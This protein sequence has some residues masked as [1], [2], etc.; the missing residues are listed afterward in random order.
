MRHVVCIALLMVAASVAAP[1][2][3][4]PLILTLAEAQIETTPDPRAR[5]PDPN[6]PAPANDLPPLQEPGV[7]TPIGTEDSTTTTTT[8]TTAEPAKGSDNQLSSVQWLGIAVAAIAVGALAVA[9]GGGGGDEPQ[10][11]GSSG[12]N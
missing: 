11:V 4:D 10:Q 1:A 7:V 6:A 12:G 8:T 3:A 9:A 2:H 5:P